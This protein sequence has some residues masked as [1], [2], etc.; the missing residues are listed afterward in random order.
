M[1]SA[2]GD[3]GLSLAG[4]PH[5]D[6][7]GSLPAHGSPA[8]FA[9]Y[10][11]LRRLLTPRHPPSALLR[12]TVLR[13]HRFVLAFACRAFR[14]S[15]GKVLATCLL[16]GSS[17]RAGGCPPP[18]MG[19]SRLELL[20][21]P[22]SEGCS[23]RLSYRPHLAYGLWRMA[24]SCWLMPM[25]DNSLLA[26]GYRLYAIGHFPPLDRCRDDRTAPCA[27]LRP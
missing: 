20:T 26:I 27:R 22:L 9:V 19:L 7:A 12:L 21:F 1:C 11:V 8:L 25:A 18:S 14:Y 3:E 15:V 16:A 10:H 5:S 6:I 24:D 2:A 13:R 17:F 4:F 23:N